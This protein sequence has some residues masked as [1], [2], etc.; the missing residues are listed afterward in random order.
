MKSGFLQRLAGLFRPCTPPADAS[1]AA[2]AKSMLLAISGEMTGICHFLCD[3]LGKKVLFSTGDETLWPTRAGEAVPAEAW[4][5]PEDLAPFKTAWKA[6]LEGAEPEIRVEYQAPS[7]GTTRYLKLHARRIHAAE[8]GEPRIFGT[9]QDETESRRRAEN[10][11]S[12]NTLLRS[13]LDNLPGF[14]FAKD[15]DRNFAYLMLSNSYE[16][17]VGRVPA[18]C[19]G[20]T[21]EVLF[22]DSFR[23]IRQQD[24][25]LAA[26]GEDFTGIYTYLR[27]DGQTA[28]VRMSKRLL[29]RPDGSRV[30]LGMG[31]DITRERELEKEK[32]E[33]GRNMAQ[34]V[35]EALTLNKSLEALSNT[36][37]FD[38]S[39]AALL[40]ELGLKSGADHTTIFLCEK[41]RE[42][43]FSDLHEWV[44]EGTEPMRDM[45]LGMKADVFSANCDYVKEH[46]YIIV[47]DVDAP[48][49]GLDYLCTALKLMGVQSALIGGIW[50]N[51]RLAGLCSLSY[52]RTRHTYD[53]SDKRRI[54]NTAN[55]YLLAAEREDMLR[56][57]ADTTVI[58]KQIFDSIAVP[59]MVFDLDHTITMVNPATSETT[60]TPMEEL[61]GK[62]CHNAL[63]YADAPPD[64]CPMRR[65][66]AE[67][68][69][70]QMEYE[71]HG[72]QYIINVQPIFDHNGKM[73]SVVEIAHDI[74]LQKE[75][76]RQ[77]A[78]QNLLLNN[79]AGIAQITYFQGTAEADIEIIGGNR[80]IGLPEGYS[81]FYDWLIPEDREMFELNRSLIVG[82]RTDLVEMKCRSDAT[83]QRRSYRLVA[84]RDKQDPTLFIGILQDV[85]Q[86]TVLEEERLDLIKAL[87]NYIENEKIVNAG[88][89]QI[90]AEENFEANV[91]AILKIIATHLDSDR[92]YLGLFDGEAGAY[93]L[94]AEWHTP[95]ED[96]LRTMP[97]AKLRAQFQQWKEDIFDKDELLVIEDTFSSPYADLFKGPKCKTLIVAPIWVQKEFYGVLG[98]GFIRARRK[99][100]D[101][102]RNIMRSVARLIALAREH[103]LQREAFDQ[104]QR[105]NTIMLNTTPFP[106]VLFNTEGKIVT[107]NQASGAL[108]H[109]TP[110]EMCL[111]PCYE[112]LCG[113]PG[114]PDYCPV[115]NALRTGEPYSHEILTC[116]RDCLVTATP[117]R[118][119]QGQITHVLESAVDLTDINERKRQLETAVRTAEAAVKAA[120]VANQTKSYFLATMSH[121]LR[122]PLNAV[123]GFS[124]LLRDSALNETDRREALESIHQAGT[125]LLELIND[126]LDL[127]KIE[128]EKMEIL[129]EWVNAA[130]FLNGISKIF[131]LSAKSK[132]LTFNVDIQ[133]KDLPPQVYLDRKHI[134]QVLVNLLGNA[135]KFTRQGSVTFT[136]RF[137]PAGPET[138]AFRLQVADTGAGMSEDNVKELFVA[139]KQHHVR[140]AEGTGLGLVISQRL[141]TKMGGRIGVEST[142]G[143]GTAFTVDLPGLPYRQSGETRPGPAPETAA[144][145]TAAAP[146]TCA[147]SALLVDDVVMNLKI[148]EA[149]MKRL[150]IPCILAESAEEALTLIAKE[151][152]GIILTDLWMP[153]M[154]GSELA[155][156]LAER[157]ETRAIPIIA[158]T[159]DVQV[160]PER[161][162]L[163]SD[164][165][166]KPITLATLKSTLERT[167]G[168]G[169]GEKSSHPA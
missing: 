72:K 148:L 77:V 150:G 138:G 84:T 83:G 13:M 30:I 134:R 68:R 146:V 97:N 91:D 126:V 155:M 46:T 39:I 161:R 110:D 135:F 160:P 36:A 48:P 65:V 108:T 162:A 55:L 56:K 26:T 123:I 57:L 25:R 73:V 54:D 50:K 106:I 104:L 6:L 109:R 16:P 152:P 167:L 7:A 75:Q 165:L 118:D 90:L 41:D 19:I 137:E 112:S 28:Y 101:L 10:L 60:G 11:D 120:E 23:T 113:E 82:G 8:N 141:V 20:L 166:F 61:I 14:I 35:Q 21:D 70:A 136:A 49:P 29:T 145:E 76:S 103:T 63:C 129:P 9:I 157:E 116:G 132:S 85:T 163:F 95:G 71:G 98:V 47:D 45:F 149:M 154:D 44:S 33:N 79:A 122:T 164:I 111:H 24:E 80:A 74:S 86:N 140:D 107:C 105:F 69:P 4:M 40:K 114:V 51:G 66:I 128:A 67:Q 115:K 119:S 88:L 81:K 15:V 62:K 2:D 169:P 3:P 87:N 96:S 18:D 34:H 27:P 159:A 5:R 37:D 22:P 144:P 43:V 93:R 130:D 127:S 131:I 89:S 168:L 38:T 158:V 151:R 58:Y 59:I 12:F 31:F 124:E 102:D 32:A 17:I 99:F 139:F 117:I 153:S 78:T 42:G 52:L 133:S 53:E 92:S 121:E 125:S 94:L 142:L 156:R 147:G 143:E 1:R 100:T 64:W